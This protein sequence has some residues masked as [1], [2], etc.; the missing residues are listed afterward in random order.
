[1]SLHYSGLR[2]AH[3]AENGWHTVRNAACPTEAVHLGGAICTATGSLTTDG[4]LFTTT[5]TGA[6]IWGQADAFYFVSFPWSLG[7][8]TITA[9]VK[10]V[11]NA[12]AWSKAGVMLRENLAAGSKHVMAVVT[13]GKGIAMQY[14]TSTSGDSAQV[15]QVPG[16]APA[17][18]RVVK[19]VNTVTAAWSIDGEQWNTL[20]STTITF[21]R[22][23]FYVGLPT[24]SHNAGA[25]TTATFDDVRVGF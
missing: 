13:P 23:T 25:S 16:V 17:W 2:G 4:V 14:R 10:S 7:D 20:G 19:R 5:G 21:T 11:S 3:P 1:M 9:R 15:S 22:N 24:T 18:V 8:V 12:H 6:D